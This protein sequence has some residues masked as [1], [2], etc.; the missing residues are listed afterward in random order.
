[1]KGK[2]EIREKYYNSIIN[3]I[4]IHTHGCIYLHTHA[5]EE[6][7][8]EMTQV[9]NVLT[10]NPEALRSILRIYTVESKNLLLLPHRCKSV[11]KHTHIHPK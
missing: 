11:S 9:V 3:S 10:A 6:K 5:C 8:I 4:Y 2:G 7:G 1:M